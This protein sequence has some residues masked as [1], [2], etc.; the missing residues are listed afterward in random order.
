MSDYRGEPGAPPERALGLGLLGQLRLAVSFLTIIP[1]LGCASSGFADLT[2]SFGWFPLVGF[3]LGAIAACADFCLRRFLRPAARAV[4]I[5]MALAVVTGGVHLDG[6]ADTADALG[7]GR[8]RMR[9]LEI[10]RDS[11]I[12]T[13][14]AIALFFIL[15]LKLSALAGAVHTGRFQAIFLAPGLGRWAM[16]M[17]AEGMTYLRTEGAGSTLLGARGARNWWVAT[18]IS[19]IGVSLTRSTIG[20]LAAG[21]AVL[22]SLGL[23]AFYRRWLGGVTGDLIGAAGEI[24]ETAVLLAVAN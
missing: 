20:W 7:A 5:V 1:V 24:V 11:R 9:A 15:I 17:T 22:L 6:L 12:G 3:A 19:I 21:L 14:G 8:D 2:A 18:L 13:F 16:V 10:L 4:L 23:R